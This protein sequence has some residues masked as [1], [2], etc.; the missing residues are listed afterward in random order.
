MIK[1]FFAFLAVSG[2][3]FAL[4]GIYFITLGN[5]VGSWPSVEGQI[6]SVGIKT[7]LPGSTGPAYTKE[8]R[9]RLREYYPQID[10]RWNINDIEYAGFRYR[11]GETHE[12]YDSRQE[13]RAAAK[14]FKQ[15]ESISVYYDPEDPS[16][17]VLDKTT[18]FSIYVP[19]IIGLLF[20]GTGALGL[21]YEEAIS[22]AAME[23]S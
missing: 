20:L 2:L 15:G 17:A 12:K 3:A 1:L 14:K 10:Y 13:A 11:L 7:Q 6:V 19:L 18:T 5:K 4:F 22:K 21:R 16:Q 23:S 9:D 8:Q